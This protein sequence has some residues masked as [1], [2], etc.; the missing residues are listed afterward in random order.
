MHTC[1]CLSVC[2]LM[3]NDKSP[4][5]ISILDNK[6]RSLGKIACSDR[7]SKNLKEG[8]NSDDTH[9]HTIKMNVYFDE[10]GK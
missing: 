10:I 6:L 7:E 4:S 3:L 1:M 9:S 2:L 5:F 8:K